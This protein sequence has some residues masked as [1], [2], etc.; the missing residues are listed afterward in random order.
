L[1]TQGDQRFKR[2][3]RNTTTGIGNLFKTAIGHAFANFLAD[4]LV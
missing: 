2:G 1:T 3:R 4:S